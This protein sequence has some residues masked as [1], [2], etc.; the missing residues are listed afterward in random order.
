MVGQ[1]LAR[2]TNSKADLPL[3]QKTMTVSDALTLARQ[4]LDK[5]NFTEATR[6][7]SQ[8]ADHKRG[9]ADAFHILAMTAYQTGRIDKAISFAERAVARAP[10]TAAFWSNLAEML[11]RRGFLTRARKAAIQATRLDPSQALSWSNLSAIEFQRRDYASAENAIRKALILEPSCANHYNVLGNA[12]QRQSR[13]EEAH[14]AFAGALAVDPRFADALVNDAMC[15]RDAGN[16]D[17]ALKSINEALRLAPDHANAHLVR[18]TIYFLKGDA[19]RGRVE[20]EWR[21]ALPRAVPA[22]LTGQRWRGEDIAGKRLL[23]FAEQGLGDTIQS[24]RYISAL[25]A[26]GISNIVLCVPKHLRELAEENFPAIEVVTGLSATAPADYHVAM[27]SLC[28][29]IEGPQAPQ[30]QPTPQ[31]AYLTASVERLAQWRKRFEPYKGRKI[32]LVWAGNTNYQSDHMRSM[33]SDMLVPLLD[34]PG[35]HFFSLQIGLAAAGISALKPQVEDL[36][37]LVG[38]MADAAAA[39][40][41]LDLVITV[42]T[43]IGHLAGALGREAWTMLP[44]VPDWRWGMSGATHPLYSSTQLFRQTRRGDWAGVVSDIRAALTPA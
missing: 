44:H 5:R 41:A 32:G 28:L 18:A 34:A 22:K 38:N 37:A 23:V 19:G 33:A 20:Y 12:L 42:D 25:Q 43:S 4:F 30:A 6:V 39:I 40:A 26:R 36:S 9:H 7:A 35:C 31:G 16:F 15:W 1:A 17:H 3:V 14:E 8:I 24:L 2:D 27:M 13:D 29:M 11:R 21:L 10:K